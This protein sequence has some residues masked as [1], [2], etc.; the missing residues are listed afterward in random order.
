MA[1]RKSKPE[2]K[3]AVKTISCSEAHPTQDV[4]HP[5]GHPAPTDGPASADFKQMAAS[6]AVEHAAGSRPA[7]SL[8]ARMRNK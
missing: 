1:K 7:R 2:E 5:D 4:Y 6:H 3:P 8:H